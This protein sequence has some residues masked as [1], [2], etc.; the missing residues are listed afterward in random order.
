MCFQHLFKSETE[1]KQL[2]HHCR[3]KLAV[4]VV[5]G[6]HR[7]Q[8]VRMAARQFWDSKTDRVASC[9]FQ[10]GSLFCCATVHAVYQY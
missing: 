5:I 2:G 10:N 9:S 7:A 1:M 6:E 8:G 3:Y 4:H